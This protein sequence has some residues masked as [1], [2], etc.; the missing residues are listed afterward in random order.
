MIGIRREDKSIWERRV[1]LIPEDIQELA[2]KSGLSFVVQ[3]SK[4]RIFKDRAFKKA[5][6]TVSEDLSACDIVFAV[7]EIPKNL[8]IN[9]KTYMFFSHVIKGQKQNMPM[10][11]KIIE[12]GCTLIDYE[13]VTDDKGRRLVFFGRHAGLAGMIDSLWALGKRLK[14]EGVDT[15]FKKVKQAWKYKTLD[16]AKDAISK[17]GKHIAKKGFHPSIAPMVCGF[18]GYGNVSRG[19]Q[20]IL[21]VLPVQEVS[22][23]DL[24][25]LIESGKF[26][27]KFVYKVVFYE[28]DIVQTISPEDKF[29]LQDYFKYPDKYKGIFTQYVPHLTMLINC[30]YWDKRYPR[31]IT[32][33][34]LKQM[35][36]AFVPKLKVIGDISC[37]VEGAIEC[38]SKCTDPGNPVFVWD[39]N[40]EE[41]IDGVVGDGPVVL[42]VDILPS[43]LSRRSSID[44]SK[45]LREF[46]PAIAKADY[47]V[48]F[49]A[50]D[51]P[52]DIKRA[53]IVHKGKLTPD[54]EYL[55][56]YLVE[57]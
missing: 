31:L 3:P 17:V 14:D 29:E 2:L 12:N 9:N 7:K 57:S 23:Q 28:K 15:P 42:A 22:P 51:L 48:S 19:A 38:T 55:E 10:L 52:A 33:E 21:D 54:Y 6:A 50:L 36:S 8:I 35:Y 27:N 46:V 4:N 25:S 20:E 49:E 5:G 26:S 47:N 32:K 37:D 30:I 44:F 39:V 11:K 43:E 16:D 41:A 45:V 53:M 18:A 56:K 40:K 24:H 1:P 34:Y 13:K